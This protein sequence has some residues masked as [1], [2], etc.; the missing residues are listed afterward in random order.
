M[1]ADPAPSS[2]STFPAPPSRPARF[3]TWVARHPLVLVA[4]LSPGIVEY[5]SGSSALTGLVVAPPLFLLLLAGNL[6][7]YVPGVLLIREARIRWN[8]GWGS[9]LLLAAAYGIVEEGL[10]LSTLFNS[11]AGVVGTLGFYGH[12]LG[13]SWVWLV[14]VLAVHMVF[15]ISM[16][17]Y[18][19]DLALPA[20]RGVPLLTR[21]G[22]ATAIGVLTFDTAALMAVTA[23]GLGFFAGLPLFI[24]SLA[25]V[26]GLVLLA[27][28]L[29]ADTLRARTE[30]PAARPLVL[31]LLGFAF[32]PS[33]LVV[34][35]VAGKLGAPAALTFVLVVVLLGILIFALLRLVGRRA[36][37][38]HLL[39][40][41]VGLIAPIVFV[42]VVGQF[43]LPVVLVADAAAAWFFWH[44]WRRY[45][46]IASPLPPTPLGTTA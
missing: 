18:L 22:I 15:S 32:F 35:A 45:R 25:A 41:A 4:F 21:R 12:F 1:S 39:A 30:R 14:G 37:E 20:M 6:G 26:A 3:R 33:V 42:G 27:R 8:K 5:L 40:L 13:V 31:G 2:A 17:I 29:P 16:P 9:V 23:L 38:P 43:S 46:F 44:L 28:W 36:N 7:L 10:A 11:H 19:F 24:G 34:E